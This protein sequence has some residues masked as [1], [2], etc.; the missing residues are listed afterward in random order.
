[1]RANSASRPSRAEAARSDSMSLRSRRRRLLPVRKS[2]PETEK[3]GPA[4]DAT[5]AFCERYPLARGERRVAGRDLERQ[6]PHVGGQL[7]DL[8]NS[9]EEGTRLAGLPQRPFQVQLRGRR[10]HSF[11]RG[12]YYHAC[13]VGECQLRAQLTADQWRRAPLPSAASLLF[14]LRIHTSPDSHFP[15]DQLSGVDKRCRRVN[16][17]SRGR[18]VKGPCYVPD[19][20]GG[21]DRGDRHQAV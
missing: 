19:E 7:R 2:Q 13:A 1:M 6:L 16:L 15:I 12:F 18:A 21:R 11:V 17:A 5:D 14:S 9:R 4:W 10:V 8:A 20:P 3:R